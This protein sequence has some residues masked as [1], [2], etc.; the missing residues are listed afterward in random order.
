MLGGSFDSIMEG[1]GEIRNTNSEVVGGR[2]GKISRS[3]GA[4]RNGE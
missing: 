4:Y 1:I 3:V 2:N